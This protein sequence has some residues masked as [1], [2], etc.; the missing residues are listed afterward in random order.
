MLI[1]FRLDM[2]CFVGFEWFEGLTSDFW[3]ENGKRKLV[4]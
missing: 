3:A 4:A 1:P 2:A